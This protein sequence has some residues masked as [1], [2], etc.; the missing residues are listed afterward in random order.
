M[1]LC[2]WLPEHP[3]GNSIIPKQ[4]LNVDGT[5]WFETYHASRKSFLYLEQFYIGLAAWPL[6]PPL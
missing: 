4:A 6:A 5:V 1:T 2:R 3:G